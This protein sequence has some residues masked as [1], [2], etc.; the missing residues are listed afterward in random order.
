MQFPCPTDRIPHQYS[1]VPTASIT[2]KNSKT[3]EVLL[4][5]RPGSGFV[6]SEHFNRE[7]FSYRLENLGAPTTTIDISALDVECA[8]A[9]SFINDWKNGHSK[10]GIG[11][12]EGLV[13]ARIDSRKNFAKDFFLPT[14]VNRAS[15]VNNLA[16]RFFACLFAVV[17]DIAS[18]PLR[19][20][21]SPIQA[22]YRSRHPEIHP[23]KS[24]LPGD[25][26][27]ADQPKELTDALAEGI[28]TVEY[29]L[30]TYSVI[31]ESNGDIRTEENTTLNVAQ[32][33]LERQPGFNNNESAETQYHAS[34]LLKS[35]GNEWDKIEN[36]YPVL[37]QYL[38]ATMFLPAYEMKKNES[39]TDS[40][41]LIPSDWTWER[42]QSL[43]VGNA[44]YFT[45]ST[46][47]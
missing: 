2:V 4:R 30:H 40:R 5:L 1:L 6:S 13:C 35:G 27:P 17:I 32:I 39:Q 19:L 38:D 15:K 43:Y 3:R 47:N 21:I 42:G 14:V 36:T 33:A 44:N 26:A 12:W 25:L 24:L 8:D 22:I 46:S 20:L 7:A 37:A 31:K 11:F 23:L 28:V 16:L 10:S 9:R 29:A 18:F 41:P 34:H 45:A